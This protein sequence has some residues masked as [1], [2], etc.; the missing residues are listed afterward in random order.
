MIIDGLAYIENKRITWVHIGGGG[1][2]DAL[3]EQAEK[4]LGKK[5]NIQYRFMGNVVNDEVI[6]FYKE[7]YVG[8]FI[9]T[10]Q[11]EGGSP[12]SVQEALSF[13]VPIIATSGGELP[14]MVKSNGIILPSTPQK[15]EVGRA[16]ETMWEIYGTD[17][18]FSMCG[19]SLAIFRGMFDEK[20]NYN[21]LVEEISGSV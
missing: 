6:R 16:I 17:S 14:L 10:T 11:T 7:N 2:L 19:E 13:G 8:C 21:G 4:Q 1:K 9:T 5:P 20:M 15:A 3:K 18:Y 12:V